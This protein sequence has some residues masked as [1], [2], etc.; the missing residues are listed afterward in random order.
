MPEQ[1]H[2]SVPPF[3]PAAA[4]APGARFAPQQS[5]PDQSIV[6]NGMTVRGEISGPDAIYV[7]GAIEG[8]INIPGERVTVGP[9][10]VV[11]GT[12][13]TPC[14]TAREIVILGTVRGNIVAMDRL[15][16]RAN[17][18][19]TGN[20]STMRLKIEDG[21]HF[22]GGIEIREPEV[23]PDVQAEEE[24]DPFEMSHSRRDYAEATY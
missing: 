9:N 4:P 1:F 15:E 11:S 16:I 8:S 17:G 22:Q 21:S 5:V 2:P 23:Q 19:V 14:I 3:E 10:G 12:S 6:T 7:D 20:V 24:A 13:K 18:S